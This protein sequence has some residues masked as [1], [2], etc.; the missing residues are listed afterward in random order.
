MKKILAVLLAMLMLCGGMAVGASAAGVDI[1]SKFTDP[2]FLAAVREEIDK[3][4]GPIFDTD[5]A[6]VTWLNAIGRN[7]HSLAGLE[8]FVG[9]EQLICTS[10]KLT[11]LPKLPSSLR[12]LNC[13]FNE[14]AMLPE[15][16]SGLVTLN[17]SFNKLASLPELSSC[18][19][20]LDCSDNKLTSL[21][22][23]PASLRRLHCESNQLTSIDVTG[24]AL[25][26]I[27]CRYNNLANKSAVTG[28]TG[29]WDNEHFYFD[30]QNGAAGFSAIIWQWILKYIFFGWLW[31]R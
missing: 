13:S 4:T 18:L 28:F 23:L 16:P 6:E 11:S 2:A 9:L 15:L 3:P 22:E 29:K 1:T 30:P 10:N 21:P 27:N 26:Q 5:V 31:N 24:L 20:V 25:T 14:L 17:C 7:V 8:Y 19:L 12:T